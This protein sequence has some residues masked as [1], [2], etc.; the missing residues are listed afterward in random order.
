MTTIAFKNGIWASDSAQSCGYSLAGYTMGAKFKA[1]RGKIAV[2]CAGDTAV[3][4][5]MADRLHKLKL[6]G[7]IK[8]NIHAWIKEMAFKDPDIDAMFVHK[9]KAGRFDI[10]YLDSLL[11]PYHCIREA[12]ALGSGSDYAIGAMLA[13]ASA[14]EAVKIAAK[15]DH[16][17]DGPIYGY[18]MIKNC[19]FTPEV[20]YER[21]INPEAH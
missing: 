14:V 15:I 4:E 11:Y 10:Y 7:N 18:D 21:T 9:N 1:L 8:E 6:T 12:H 3:G 17:T 16:Y 20:N 13:G 5:A 2:A 19:H